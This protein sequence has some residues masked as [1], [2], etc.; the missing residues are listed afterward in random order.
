MTDLGYVSDEIR[1]S[2]LKPP[3]PAWLDLTVKIGGLLVGFGALYV[4]ALLYYGIH[5]QAMDIGYMPE[6]PVAYSH[7]LH[8]GELGIDCRYC[9]S[10]VE[11]TAFA[12]VPA[13]QTCM[14]C[15]QAIQPE[16]EI[17]APIRDSYATGMPVEWMRVHD[18]PDFVYF[19]HSA[20]VRRGV[21]CVECHGRVDEMET[22]YQAESLSMAW[23]L[24]CHR[25][26]DPK[27]RPLEAIT[28]MAWAP[29]GN[30]EILGRELRTANGIN[31]PT[32]C[33]TCHR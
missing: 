1:S 24:D 22:V 25:N 12:T 19:N 3:F 28:N 4:V 17:L 31:P 5:P 33:S 16:S 20:H 8:A 2:D 18:L 21:G 27:L 14:N 23:C 9:H 13:T 29:D 26:P 10:T 32:D 15:H 6:Q 11:E 30:P 7:R